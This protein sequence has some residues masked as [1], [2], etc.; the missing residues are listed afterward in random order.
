MRRWR[1]EEESP[2]AFLPCSGLERGSRQ[3]AAQSLAHRGGSELRRA[4][5][6]LIRAR[7]EL[8]FCVLLFHQLVHPTHSVHP[9]CSQRSPRSH[10]HPSNRCTTVCRRARS[11]EAHREQLQP[12]LP[13]PQILL[14]RQAAPQRLSLRAATHCASIHRSRI[15]SCID[16]RWRAFSAFC[17]STNCTQPC[18]SHETG[19]QL[20]RRC[21]VW[22]RASQ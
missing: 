16:M 7:N 4:T 5:S 22:R 19:W 21:A 10:F 12:L 9:S 1:E 2:S 3:T 17:P 14:L 8:I 6:R 20:S 18:W 13:L 11:N 15:R